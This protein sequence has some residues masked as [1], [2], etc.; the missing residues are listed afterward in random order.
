M[1]PRVAPSGAFVSVPTGHPRGGHGD[2]DL[3]ALK[4]Q[5]FVATALMPL[6][7]SAECWSGR[8]DRTTLQRHRGDRLG[9]PHGGLREFLASPR[10]TRSMLRRFLDGLERG[11]TN[12]VMIGPSVS[13]ASRLT[14]PGALILAFQ[15]TYLAIRLTNRTEG[16]LYWGS[17]HPRCVGPLADRGGA[18]LLRA[19]IAGPPQTRRVCSDS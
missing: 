3:M 9:R 15:T 4:R 14:R 5:L 2:S 7:R 16:A 1:R 6:V 12:A 13:S 19:P 8:S 18:A 10:G 17:T 11:S